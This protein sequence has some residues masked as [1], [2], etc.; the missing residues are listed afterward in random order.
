M[1]EYKLQGK[2]FQVRPIP[3]DWEDTICEDMQ[4]VAYL[5]QTICDYEK[6]LYLPLVEEFAKL[7][8]D[9]TYMHMLHHASAGEKMN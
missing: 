1:T 6:T 4:Q 3:P 8:I 2:S 7:Y 9:A 5:I